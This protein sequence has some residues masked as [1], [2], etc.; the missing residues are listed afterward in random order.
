MGESPWAVSGFES[1]LANAGVADL[2]DYLVEL[3]ELALE[4]GLLPHSNA[5]LLGARRSAALAAV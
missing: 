1:I 3:C 4:F 5:G 2:M